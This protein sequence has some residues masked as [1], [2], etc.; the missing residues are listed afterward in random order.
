LRKKA[1]AI[2]AN[3]GLIFRLSMQISRTS[4]HI[5]NPNQYNLIPIHFFE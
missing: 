1:A 5:N 2:T 4:N 3:A